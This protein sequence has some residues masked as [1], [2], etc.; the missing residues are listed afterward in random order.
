MKAN[1]RL[2]NPMWQ[3]PKRRAMLDK[4]VQR[5][6]A[7][8]ESEVKR[9]ITE[10]RPA[11]KTYRRGAITKKATKSNLTLGLRRSKKNKNRVIAGSNFHRASKRGQA[12]AV[13][14]GGL[15]NSIR[16]K[17]TGELKSTVAVGKAYGE[18]L[19]DPARLDRPFFRST[20][21]EYLPKF[22]ENIREVIKSGG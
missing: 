18:I 20:V 2:N 3:T 17:K 1:L 9:T 5:S 13:D 12:P 6:G 4:A 15:L 14:T 7:E 10:S 21:K 11:G 22:K 19:D 16:A 8:L